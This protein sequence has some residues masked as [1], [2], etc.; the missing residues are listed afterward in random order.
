MAQE[1]HALPPEVGSLGGRIAVVTGAS[2]GFGEA[3]A[4]KLGALGALVV[5]GAR[6]QDRLATVRARIQTARGRGAAVPLDVGGRTSS[7]AFAAEVLRRHGAI[8]ILVNNAGL[9]RG[10]APVV[11]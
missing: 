1:P 8:D 9:A 5:L 4:T 11:D 7:E 2:S 10:F 6:R 3:V